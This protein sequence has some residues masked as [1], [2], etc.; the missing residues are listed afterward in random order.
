MQNADDSPI[1]LS[2]YAFDPWEGL[3]QACQELVDGNQN[4][5][6]TQ[7]SQ[8]LRESKRSKR[9]V[10]RVKKRAHSSAGSYVFSRDRTNGKRLIQIKV[11]DLLSERA[12]SSLREPNE[13]E[14]KE[15]LVLSAQYV[16]QEPVDEI[17]DFTETLIRKI[18][19][20]LCGDSY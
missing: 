17:M 16:V 11:C 3:T 5:S 12:C 9:K 6:H 7:V 8:T 19:K 2:Q 18:S 1:M 13:G 20:R 10:E 4:E 14:D 15:T